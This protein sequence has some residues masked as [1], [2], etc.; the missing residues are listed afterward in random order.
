M[1]DGRREERRKVMA[2]Q[3]EEKRRHIE[4][5]DCCQDVK[6]RSIRLRW[7]E[8]LKEEKGVRKRE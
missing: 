6:E 7:R 1:Q 3:G 2:G 5:G 4:R 8:R